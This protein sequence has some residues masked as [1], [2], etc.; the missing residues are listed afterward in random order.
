MSQCGTVSG[1][2]TPWFLLWLVSV[3]GCC[4]PLLGHLVTWIGPWR[5][6]S[7]SSLEGVEFVTTLHGWKTR[8]AVC[9]GEFPRNCKICV[10]NLPK[11]LGC[12]TFKLVP[13]KRS[14]SW[15]PCLHFGFD[16]RTLQSQRRWET[17]DNMPQTRL[18]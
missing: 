13:R 11:K 4:D 9:L 16:A 1:I 10:F 14:T 8:S 3:A 18:I 2:L 5:G 7:S 15:P 12:E 6:M 17:G